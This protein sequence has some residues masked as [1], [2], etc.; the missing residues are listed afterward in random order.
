MRTPALLIPLALA[1]L[2]PAAAA[3]QSGPANGN[4][5][6]SPTNS[7]QAKVDI[8][9]YLAPQLGALVAGGN[10]TLGQGGSLAGPGH[11]TVS[12]RANALQGSLPDFRGFAP[13][14]S[15]D[16]AKFGTKS[17]ALLLPIVD[18]SIGVF[19]GFS[20][21][22]TKVGGLDLLATGSYLPAFNGGSTKIQ[23]PNGA[24]KFGYGVRVGLLQEGLLTP[25]VGVTWVKRDL[26]IVNVRTGTATGTFA[27]DD[28]DIRTTSWR[29]T[30]SKSLIAFGVAAGVGRDSYTASGTVSV[31]SPSTA[32]PFPV[33]QTVKRLSY[34]G[35]VSMNF[36]LARV[37]AEIGGV[38]GGK[39]QTYNSFAGKAS[40][41]F[42][43]YGSLGIRAGI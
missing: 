35:D 7:C 32:I 26:P 15:A 43:L 36:F 8:F 33:S 13:T 6:F 14:V 38:S 31:P 30:A 9:A 12:V 34:F 23:V 21:G 17:A 27:L 24:L 4:C 19:G 40:D 1:C 39:S 42:R 5:G 18:A 22:V 10:A 3:A 11:L 28:V 2:T 16:R 41:A 25:G 20:A 29:L 37:I